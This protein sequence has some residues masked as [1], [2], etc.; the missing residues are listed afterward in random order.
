MFS[1]RN[2]KNINTF[3]LKKS[4]F[5]RSMHDRRTVS[6]EVNSSSKDQDQPVEIYSLIRNFAILCYVL[7]YLNIL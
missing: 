1:W 4:A 7:Q 5:T 6:S 2:K 3:G